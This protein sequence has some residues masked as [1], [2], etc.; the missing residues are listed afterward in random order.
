MSFAP[1]NKVKFESSKSYTTQTKTKQNKTEQKT[2][3]KMFVI[4][5]ENNEK[6]CIP[7]P[8]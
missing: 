6:M 3:E 7:K 2:N 1:S 8:R 5:H 4:N